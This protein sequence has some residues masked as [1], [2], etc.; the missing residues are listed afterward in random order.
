MV[1]QHLKQVG[2]VKKFDKWVSHELTANQKNCFEA[3]S[4]LILCNNDKPFL[5]RI[6]TCNG[7]WTVYDK[8][9]WSAQWLDQKD[10][11]KH[12]PKPNLQEKMIMIIFWGSTAG[13]MHYSFLNP[14]ETINT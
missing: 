10:A 4:S 6:V 1:I 12:F 2:N 11:P 5:N 9:R 8:Q 13:L 3:S 14:S 7:K